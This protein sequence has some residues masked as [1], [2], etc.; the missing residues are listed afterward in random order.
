MAGRP[1]SIDRD[2]VLDVAEALVRDHGASHL[3][4]DAVAKAAGITKGGVQYCFGTKENLIRAM[5]DRWGDTFEQMVAEEA[6]PNPDP[7]S[8]IRAHVRL[9]GDTN[10]EEDS[11]AAVMI[12][13]LLHSPEQRAATRDWYGSRLA[14]LDMTDPGD[15][16][17][18][19]GLMAGEGAFILKALGLMEIPAQDWQRIFAAAVALATRSGDSAALYP[20]QD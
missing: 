20:P 6:G 7:A 18:A 11:R 2:H 3:T 9:T 13:A 14:G 1:R 17:V 15:L 16:R 5:V 12:S 19:L 8:V 10:P 4:F